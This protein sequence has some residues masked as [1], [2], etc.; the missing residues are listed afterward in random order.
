MAENENFCLVEIIFLK[1]TIPNNAEFSFMEEKKLE[2]NYLAFFPKK[3]P[4]FIKWALYK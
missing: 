3:Y 1:K 4:L 2:K